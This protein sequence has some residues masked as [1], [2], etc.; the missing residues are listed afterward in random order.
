MG[1][2]KHHIVT[3]KNFVALKG[4]NEFHSCQNL[5]GYKQ[6]YSF[7]RDILGFNPKGGPESR[8]RE[9]ASLFGPKVHKNLPAAMYNVFIKENFVREEYFSLS[10]YGR[11]WCIFHPRFVREGLGNLEK[12]EEVRKDK[13][14]NLTPFAVKHG[15]TPSECK[16]FFG[17]SLWKKLSKNS[18]SRNKILTT[19]SKTALETNPWLLDVRSGILYH[20]PDTYSLPQCVAAKISPTIKDFWHTAYI[21]GDT[22]RMFE[23]L[24]HKANLNWSYSRWQE[25]HDKATRKIN[26]LRFSKESF[27]EPFSKAVEGFTFTL[28]TS[29]FEV[30]QEG[31]DMNH[32]VGSYAKDCEAGFYE[33]YKVEGK[34]QRVTLG[35][36]IRDGGVLHLDQIYGKFNSHCPEDVYQAALKFIKEESEGED[37]L[38]RRVRRLSRSSN[39]DTRTVFYGDFGAAAAVPF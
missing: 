2:P 22:L 31:S 18:K 10:L 7:A 21:V 36:H 26:S 17:K 38:G 5:T 30:G 19:Y 39:K 1:L 33:V 20:T 32:C 29:P 34:G 16:D 27:V 14:F 6:P 25:E 12:V 37:S 35:V 9:V 28:L 11:R 4:A 3:D 15:M 13:L 23:E 24:G 8:N